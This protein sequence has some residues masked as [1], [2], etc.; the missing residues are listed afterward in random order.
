MAPEAGQDTSIDY[1]DGGFPD[2]SRL[3]SGAPRVRQPARE[4]P[5]VPRVGVPSNVGTQR[6]LDHAVSG[7]GP[8]KHP[9]SRPPLPMGASMDDY[10]RRSREN[11][12]YYRLRRAP[13]DADIDPGDQDK[14]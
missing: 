10:T 3:K 13:R 11:D 5:D 14:K 7:D 9:D 4:D 2:G 12:E 1:G 6:D 8:I